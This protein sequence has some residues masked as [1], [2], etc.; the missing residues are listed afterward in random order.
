MSN[1]ERRN[2]LEEAHL[3]LRGKT[4]IPV[5]IDH[6]EALNE[7]IYGLEGELASLR[8][9]VRFVEQLFVPSGE[10]DSA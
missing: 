4:D 1:N 8:D 7:V 10:R 6:L 5:Q 9:A 2:Y 3:L